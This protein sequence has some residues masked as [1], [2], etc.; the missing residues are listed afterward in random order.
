VRQA[1]GPHIGIAVDFHGR[2]HRPMARAMVKDLEPHKLMFVEEA[3]LRENREALREIATRAEAYDV[4][5]APR[6][7]LEPIAL[8][9]CLQLDAVP[10]N[11]FIQEQSLG[12]HYD[13][14]NDLLDYVVNKD[15]F[16]Y[17]DGMVAI[18]DDPGLG[19]EIDEEYVRER[20]AEAHRSRNPIWRHKDGCF[21]EW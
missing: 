10:F 18:A 7:P 2:V 6:C 3:V 17:E 20:A 4:T 12:I 14:S 9:A 5:V 8:A 21:A 1:V 15:V 11:A 16:K 13:A 19:I